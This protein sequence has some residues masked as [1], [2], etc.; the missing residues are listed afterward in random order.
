M[1]K[2]N[3]PTDDT[4]AGGAIVE[5]EITLD[6]AQIETALKNIAAI[7]PP[8]D[9][10]GDTI[11]NGDVAQAVQG[12]ATTHQHPSLSL[13]RS[14]IAMME[15]GNNDFRRKELLTILTETGGTMAELMDEK[16]N[17]TGVFE[18]NYMGI[19]ATS[20]ASMATALTVWCSRAR[21]AV[22]SGIYTDDAQTPAAAE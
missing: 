12:I 11:A 3:T 17:P 13:M 18:V 14:A 2:T 22:L 1:A 10:G 16:L 19:T 20:N 9:Q 4:L 21:R 8:A 7:D 6:Q 5:A 15:S